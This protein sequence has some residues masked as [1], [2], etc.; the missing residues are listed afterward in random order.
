MLV[1]DPFFREA[2]QMVECNA[3]GARPWS[4]LG[5][6]LRITYEGTA[7]QDWGLG[8]PGPGGR[9]SHAQIDLSQV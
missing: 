9:F 4:L 5:G 8:T 7:P 3:I 1:V 2:A 6:H